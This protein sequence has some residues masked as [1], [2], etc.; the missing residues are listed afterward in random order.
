MRAV[1]VMLALAALV[2]CVADGLPIP[3][4]PETATAAP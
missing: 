3:P 4:E 1:I 2:G